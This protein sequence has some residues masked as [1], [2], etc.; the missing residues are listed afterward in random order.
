MP[1]L[2][3]SAVLLA[4]VA[5]CS[6]PPPGHLLRV[7]GHIETTEIRL[8]A[9]A[10]G[11]LLELPLREGD[12]V[13]P[14]AL[15]ARF[16]VRDQTLALDRARAELAVAEAQLRLVRAPARPEDLAQAAA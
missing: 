16:D 8:A 3:A 2:L 5:A 11:R 15:V 9:D 1:R 12:R 7:N 13:E 4:V 14:G 10:G 6:A